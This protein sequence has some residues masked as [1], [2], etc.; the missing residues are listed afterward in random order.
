MDTRLILLALTNCGFAMGAKLPMDGKGNGPGMP[1]AIVGGTDAAEDAWPWQVKLLY[2]ES[3][4]CG[5]TLLNDETVL[6]AAHCIHNKK[7]KYFRVVVGDYNRRNDEKKT[8]GEKKIRV[9]KIR[10]HPDYARGVL[11]DLAIMKL[12]KKVKFNQYIQPIPGLAN[13]T[14]DLMNSTCY[15]TGWGEDGGPW[16]SAIILQELQTYVVTNEQCQAGIVKGP[17]VT[18]DM[19]C[20][21]SEPKGACYGDSGGPLQC[22]VDGTWV[23]AGAVSWGNAD[24]NV[25]PTVYAKTSYHRDWILGNM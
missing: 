9:K 10:K 21:D 6:T 4:W 17:A 14:M 13:D 5:G 18:D 8:R 19:I 25:G 24:C 1:P 3:F 23:H 7:K 15:V 12:K 2:G 22:L 11:H 20:T 16:G